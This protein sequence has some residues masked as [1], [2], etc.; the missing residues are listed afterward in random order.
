[1][2]VW[3]KKIEVQLA[4]GAAKVEEF[5]PEEQ[6]RK[7]EK[8][9]ADIE[10][11]R[12]LREQRELEKEQREEER[13]RKER[14]RAM[15]EARMWH[16]RDEAFHSAQDLQRAALRFANRR[17]TNRDVLVLLAAAGGAYNANTTATEAAAATVSEEETD[18]RKVANKLGPALLEQNPADV[19]DKAANASSMEEFGAFVDE[20]RRMLHSTGP[21]DPEASAYWAAV[22]A[23][24]EGALKTKDPGLHQSLGAE[25][26]ALLEG[27]NVAELDT[28]E[29]EI[30][31]GMGGGDDEY[32]QAVLARLRVARARAYLGEFAH[33]TRFGSAAAANDP[34]EQQGGD[35]GVGVDVFGD[36]AGEELRADDEQDAVVERAASPPPLDVSE[37]RVSTLTIVDED[38]MLRELEAR[39]AAATSATE[40]RRQQALLASGEGAL[41]TGSNDYM[42]VAA[43]RAMG[44]DNEDELD[45]GGEVS[46]AQRNAA[47]IMDRFEPRKPRYM[48]RVHTGFDWNRYNRTHYDQDNPPPKL[49]QGYKFN[50]FYPDLIDPSKPPTYKLEADPTSPNGETLLLRFSAGPPYEDIAFRIVNRDWEHSHKH[51][52]KSQ[53]SRGILH[54]W[55]FFKKLRYRR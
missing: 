8:R 1:M 21:S 47:A 20:V 51:G 2:F 45:F 19:V 9:L 18:P 11:V 40:M 49:V 7:H 5:T 25:V 12:K 17:A 44:G 28:L 15:D 52:F 4:S 6:K 41:A 30:R 32:W 54:L 22:V 27:K 50:I 48:N 29:G 43:S 33:R 42:R 36:A 14:Q 46:V 26:L 16:A 53:Y 37:A 39:R 10:A 23:V 13:E 35:A 38:D 34:A 55:F 31:Q 24:A 3:K